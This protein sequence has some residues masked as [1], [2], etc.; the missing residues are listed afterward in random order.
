MLTGPPGRGP[1]P[2]QPPGVLDRHH[3]AHRR[4]DVPHDDRVDRAREATLSERT[5]AGMEGAREEGELLG[6]R[7]GNRWPPT[8][9]YRRAATWCS[10]A[11]STRVEG[12]RRLCVRLATVVAALEP[13]R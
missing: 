3:D 2:A 7:A 9:G 8:R 12:P 10:P 6:G 4:G 13:D 5:R 11:R 1:R